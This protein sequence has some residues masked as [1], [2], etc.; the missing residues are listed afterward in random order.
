L[1]HIFNIH[2]TGKTVIIV[3]HSNDIA[4]QAELLFEI[5]DGQLRTV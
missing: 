3:T 4:G 2:K 5:R 1:K